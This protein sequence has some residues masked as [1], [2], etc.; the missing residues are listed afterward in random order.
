M[1]LVDRA[2]KA[3]GLARRNVMTFKGAQTSRLESDWFATILS[4]DQEIKGN[5]RLLRARARE[6]SRN[7][8]VAKSYLKLLVAN[9]IGER[10]IGY[11]AQV[12]NNSG[13]LNQAFNTKIETAWEDWAKKGNCTVDGKHSLR[14]VQNLL[15]KTLAT[16]GEA[17]VR[18]VPGFANKHRFAIQLIDADQVDPLF[19][20][21]AST[22]NNEIRMGIEV[23]EWGRPV[24]YWINKRHPSDMG[25][26]LVRERIDAKYIKHLYD[27]ERVNQTRGITWFHPVM[28]QLRMLGGYLEAELVAA[29][30]GA[31]KM[32]FIKTV[33]ASNYVQPNEDAKYK[34]DAQPG[35]VQ[36][37]PPGTEF[38]SWN[39]DHP[40]SGFPNFVISILRFVASGLGVSYNAL[41]SDLIGVNYSSMRSGLLIER[42]QWK[43]CQS[44]MQEV[45]LQG[46]FENWLPMALLSGELVL[47]TRLPE[48]F[49]AGCWKARGWQWVDPLKDVQSAILAVGAGLKTRESII[50]EYGGSVEEVFEQLAMEKKMA[51]KLGLDFNNDAKTPKVLKQDGS[52]D[53]DD[54]NEDQTSEDEAAGDTG[55]SGGGRATPGP[56]IL[57]AAGGVM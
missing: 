19:S 38:Q 54:A 23:D 14:A 16:D 36:E 43:I 25:G 35:T 48:K 4:A 18:M 7:D 41:A 51:K 31:A 33:D 11:E 15:L 5:I 22:G 24:A 20:R 26:S 2:L 30:V 53:N 29:R 39:P 57:R 28:F 55:S 49:T 8:P 27:P 46:V 37:L 50:S 13:D 56:K 32:G 9:V 12:R 47:D 34:I 6:L 44:L 10:G 52:T 40:S 42:D 3:F 1:K 17:F 45:F 21:E